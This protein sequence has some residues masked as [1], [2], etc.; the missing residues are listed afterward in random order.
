MDRVAKDRIELSELEAI[1]R[2]EVEK[3]AV[4][5]YTSKLYAI[6]DDEQKLYAVVGVPNLP[7]PWPSR[8]VIMAQVV[9]DKVVIIEDI[10][11]NP[12]LGALIHNGGI[13]R[14]NI[15]LAYKGEPA[16]TAT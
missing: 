11:D 12:L 9:G 15:I 2:A 8:V 4:K 14:D 7:R 13:P 6:L 5:S 1:T 16:P 3:Y 10:T